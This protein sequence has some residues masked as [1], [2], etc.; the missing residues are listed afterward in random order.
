MKLGVKSYCVIEGKNAS[1]NGKVVLSSEQLLSELYAHLKMDYSKFHK[2]DTL[3][4]LGVLGV[5]CLV[6]NSKE[7]QEVGDEDVALVFENKWGSSQSDLKHLNRLKKPSPSVFVYTLPNIVIGEVAIKNKWYGE[8]VFLVNE[9]GLL[10]SSYDYANNLFSLRKCKFAITGIVESVG[11]EFKCGILLV[12]E[13]E[14]GDELYE[15][16]VIQNIIK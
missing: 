10:T 12:G 7:L 8:S 14:E 5:E 11:E 16:E 15:I 6:Q 9:G 2:M 3:S 4:K 1:V 13:W